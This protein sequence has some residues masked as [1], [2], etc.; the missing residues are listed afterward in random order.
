MK[1]EILTNMT[2]SW[3]K[4]YTSPLLTTEIDVPFKKNNITMN[5]NVNKT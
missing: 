4:I 3:T 5:E 1:S 2:S